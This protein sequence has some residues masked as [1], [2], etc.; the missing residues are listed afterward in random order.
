MYLQ[1]RL[2]IDL[3][4]T[5]V[6]LSPPRNFFGGLANLLTKGRW[7]TPEELETHKLFAFVQ[8]AHRAL[9]KL[10]VNNVVRVAVGEDVIYEDPQDVP[11]DFALAMQALQKRLSLGWEPDPRAEFDLVLKHDDGVLNYVIDLDFTRQHAVGVDPIAVTVTAVP[12]ELRRGEGEEAGSYQQRISQHFETQEKFDAARARWET[13]LEMFL[14]DIADHFRTSLGVEK[15]H[16]TTQN[17]LP[18]HRGDEALSGLTSFGYPLY[19]YDPFHDLAYLMLWDSM[20]ERHRF[21]VGNMYYGDAGS[22]SYIGDTGWGYDDAR[23]HETAPAFVDSGGGVVDGSEQRMTS[24]SGGGSW[25]SSVGDFFSDSGGGGDVSGG[26]SDSG[27]GGDS[28][29]SCGSSCSSCGG[30]GCSS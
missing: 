21:H 30:G 26:G 14:N 19:G 8:S 18:Q 4:G 11:D 2:T 1:G 23:R 16:L 6:Q 7:E 9:V 29:S 3:E 24:D 17:V 27:G 12:S 28:G 20:W 13:R 5:Q 15:V 10:G 25:L 22:Y